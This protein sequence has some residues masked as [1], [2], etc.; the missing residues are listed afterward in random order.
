[1]SWNVIYCY[2]GEKDAGEII[3]VKDNES[4]P[5]NHITNDKLMVHFPIS[6]FNDIIN[7]L[8]YEKPL[9]LFISDNGAAWLGTSSREPTGDQEP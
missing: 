3:F 8:R 7:I 9:Y 4:L 2:S 1:M 6:R 5:K